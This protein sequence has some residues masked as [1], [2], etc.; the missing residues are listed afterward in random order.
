MN[1]YVGAGIINSYEIIEHDI[2]TL[3]S[4]QQPINGYAIHRVRFDICKGGEHAFKSE[5]VKGDEGY[6]EYGY[7][8]EFSLIPNKSAMYKEHPD[9]TV[10][11]ELARTQL[12]NTHCMDKEITRLPSNMQ[13]GVFREQDVI[14][15]EEELMRKVRGLSTS[16]RLAKIAIRNAK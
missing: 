8:N 11:R 13:I 6:E 9:I 12:K 15:K 14:R 16:K 7:H 1:W 2:R 5:F 4:K 3:L 10:G